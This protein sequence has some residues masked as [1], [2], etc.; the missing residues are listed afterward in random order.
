MAVSYRQSD[1]LEIASESFHQLGNHRTDACRVRNINVCLLSHRKC[2]HPSE[3]SSLR[4]HDIHLQHFPSSLRIHRCR[5]RRRRSP[6]G[7]KHRKRQ[8]D[9]TNQQPPARVQPRNKPLHIPKRQSTIPPIPPQHRPLPKTPHRIA[10]PPN[11]PPAQNPT[12]PNPPPPPP[13]KMERR[14]RRHSQEIPRGIHGRPAGA[15][16]QVETVLRAVV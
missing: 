8:R 11:L 2:F 15:D 16:A 13:R 4:N 7:R 5:W 9:T 12:P 14:P 1:R 10:N 3:R 6:R